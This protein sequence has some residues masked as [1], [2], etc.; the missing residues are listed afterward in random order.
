MES[1]E[2]VIRSV[3]FEGPD[4]LPM[5]HFAYPGAV[6][7]F[8]KSVLTKFYDKYPLD[9]AYVGC[10]D[11]HVPLLFE[12]GRF[13]DKWGTVWVNLGGGLA[14]QP[15]EF[16]LSIW[17]HLDSY[18]FP[19]PLSPDFFKFQKGNVVGYSE[20]IKPSDYESKYVIAGGSYPNTN[21]CIFERLWFLHGLEKTLMDIVRRRREIT[22]LRD[23]ILEFNLQI[24]QR[25]IELDNSDCVYFSDDV[26]NQKGMMFSPE[27]WREF[28]KPVYEE[29]FR[30]VHKAGK[31]VLYHSDGMLEEILPDLVSIGTDI[32]YPQ[33][34]ASP[35]SSW[36]RLCGGKLCIIGIDTQF[37]L[38]Y[39]SVNDVRKYVLEEIESLGSYDGGLVADVEISPEVP[40]AN[41]ET[42]FETFRKYGRYPRRHFFLGGSNVLFIR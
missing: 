25:L 18:I 11:E 17:E 15:K 27:I 14:G 13:K 7:K 19:D 6:D 41:I 26:G 20:E 34:Q 39:G 24:I 9:F 30:K 23:R 4:R 35:L 5:H 40:L 21:L 38:P 22:T 8:G 12:K 16:P 28:I 1:R 3:E 32:F 36:E 10:S 29:M 2:R 37:V 33:L 31:Y 42:A